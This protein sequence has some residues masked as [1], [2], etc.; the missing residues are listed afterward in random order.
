MTTSL[1]TWIIY[2]SATTA[3]WLTLL[4]FWLKQAEGRFAG[5]MGV[6]L[7]ASGQLAIFCAATALAYLALLFDWS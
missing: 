5:F 2:G 6:L 7:F 3:L 4:Y 1:L